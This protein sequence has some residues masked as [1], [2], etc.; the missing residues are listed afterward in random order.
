MVRTSIPKW[1]S[2][3][4]GAAQIKIDLCA[5]RFG[6]GSIASECQWLSVNTLTLLNTEACRWSF[7]PSYGWRTV[8][9][10]EDSLGC[11]LS[12]LGWAL[13]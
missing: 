2:S 10:F 3:C 6:R 13:Y 12:S 11:A 7:E 1:N 5:N 4:L 8:D 9:S